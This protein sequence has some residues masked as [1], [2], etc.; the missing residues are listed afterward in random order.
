MR[1]I[2]TEEPRL[3][4]GSGLHFTY[5]SRNILTDANI[6]VGGGEVV[7]LLGANG[8]GKSTLLRLLL[9]LLTPSQ[10][11]VC[12]CGSS[13]MALSRREIAQ[14]MAYVPQVHVTPFPYTVREVV[15]LGRLPDGGLFR[16]HGCWARVS[17][18]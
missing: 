16:S 2:A 6:V 18:V 11:K 17:M 13:L 12:L 5:R 15:M 1:A 8:A 14:K 3:I 10:G 7:S 4:K 9:G